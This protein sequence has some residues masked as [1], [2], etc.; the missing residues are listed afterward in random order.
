MAYLRP[1]S[2]GQKEERLGNKSQ[3]EPLLM[4][5]CGLHIDTLVMEEPQRERRESSTGSRNIVLIVC[6]MLPKYAVYQ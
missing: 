2:P 1:S 6:R 3:A 4:D 5:L